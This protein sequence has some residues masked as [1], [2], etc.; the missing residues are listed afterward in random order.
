MKSYYLDEIS[1][2]DLEKISDYLN[3]NATESVMERLFWIE[4]PSEV[5][6][7]V[8]TGHP[9]CE[10]HRFAVEI[11]DTWLKAEFFVR[12]SVRFR[13]DCNG[14]CNTNQ[15]EFIINYIDN[16]IKALAIQT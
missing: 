12:T 5:L 3:E 8:Q 14:Y 2:S 4:M 9:E 1:S 16:M 7:D 10:P 15:K 13:C 6:N 11:G